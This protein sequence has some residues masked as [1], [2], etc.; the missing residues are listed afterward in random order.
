MR[1]FIN[2]HYFLFDCIYT[3]KNKCIECY[4][5]LLF[6]QPYSTI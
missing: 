1:F 2:V 6:L 4:V 5:V 3:K